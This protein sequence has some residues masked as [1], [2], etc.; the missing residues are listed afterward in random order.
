M[1][2][3]RR[4]TSHRRS[5]RRLAIGIV[6]L[7]AL[8]VGG[9]AASLSVLQRGIDARAD[10]VA[11][12]YRSSVERAAPALLGDRGLGKAERQALEALREALP[13]KGADGRRTTD[14]IIQTQQAFERLRETVSPAR[15]KDPAFAGLV[16]D[17]SRSGN[18]QALLDAHNVLAQE[19]NNQEEDLLGWPFVRLLRLRP[20]LL[21]Q[22]DG[23][24][25]YETTVTL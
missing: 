18:V 13:V 4:M 11:V 12:F 24:V 10:T 5:A 25:E 6:T 9:K 15:A 19:W 20:R 23:K 2:H 22:A 7:L 21:L 16:A 3:D 14:A 17:L 1:Y 8:I